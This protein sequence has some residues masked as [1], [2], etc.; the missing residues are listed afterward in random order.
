M[1]ASLEGVQRRLDDKPQLE[2]DEAFTLLQMASAHA[3]AA[4]SSLHPYWD[5]VVWQSVRGK[6]GA[7]L[8][9]P[10][11]LAI[12]FLSIAPRVHS[13]AQLVGAL[14]QT[15]ELCLQL[16]GLAATGAVRHASFLKVALL[17]QVPRSSP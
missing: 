2:A 15:E 12:D 7:S 5:R 14:R 8:P 10:K 1:H 11:Q 17:E 16:S 3:G 6:E 13:C 4:S 9:L